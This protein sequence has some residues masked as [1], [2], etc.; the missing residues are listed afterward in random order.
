MRNIRCA[1]CGKKYDYDVDDFCPRCGSFNPPPDSGATRLEEEM[2]SR[3]QRPG[4][5]GQPVRRA[6]PRPASGGG[7]V[8]KKGN[9]RRPVALVLALLAILAVGLPV[10][11]LVVGQV[12]DTISYLTDSFSRQEEY[13]WT[14][15]E[16]VLPEGWYESYDAIA[17]S[18][19]QVVTLAGAREPWLPDSYWQV[20]PDSRCVA[21]GLWVLGTPEGET[22]SMELM[23][24]DGTRYPP[25]EL[26]AEVLEACALESISLADGQPD[27][28]LWG[29]SFY[30]LPEEKAGEAMTAVLLDGMEIYVSLE[31]EWK[32]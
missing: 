21:V 12:L 9:F 26:P 23:T 20:H 5:G 16:T 32:E 10:V 14:T 27:E 4:S 25:V 17:L 8:K 18:N 22:A 15:D 28:E 11:E 31:M 13:V 7:T 1:D 29:Y 24:E 3:F 2:L 6:A 19:G 30:L